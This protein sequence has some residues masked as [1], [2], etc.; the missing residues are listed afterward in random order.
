VVLDGIF[1]RNS[2]LSG[3]TGYSIDQ[4]I[5]AFSDG[6][7]SS[8]Q[9]GFNQSGNSASTKVLLD[10]LQDP[11]IPAFINALP[12]NSGFVKL[13]KT[14][15]TPLLDGQ[16]QTEFVYTYDL[17]T[18]IKSKEMRPVFRALLV[19]SGN[20]IKLNDSQLL[21]VGSILS[22]LFTGTTITLTRWVGTKDMDFHAA[23]IDAT[24]KYDPSTIASLLPRNTANLG[25]GG[26]IKVHMAAKLTKLNQ[27]ISAITPPAGA[28]LITPTALPTDADNTPPSSIDAPTPTGT[29]MPNDGAPSNN[30]S[31]VLD[32]VKTP[33]GTPTS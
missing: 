8:F 26:S 33:I 7:Q 25:A 12:S 23:I 18:L 28:I 15:N 32:Y 17:P 2:P 24:I 11:S 22:R 9:N 4:Q 6:F 31:S 14:A 27:P 20:G 1:Y 5:Q 30:G 10:F 13:T 29:P 16:K 19:A 3:W 21:A